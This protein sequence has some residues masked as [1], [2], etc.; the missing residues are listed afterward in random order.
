MAR[1]HAG[2]ET[3]VASVVAG[4]S[5]SLDRFIAH[6]DDGVE[7]LFLNGGLIDEV[8]VELVPRVVG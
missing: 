7:H 8:H 5:M 2:K 6:R 3:P 1:E 4:L